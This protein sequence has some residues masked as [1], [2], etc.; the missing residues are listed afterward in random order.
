MD[1][2]RRMGIVAGL[3]FI[4]ATL[5][6]LAAA[7]LVPPRS[8]ADYLS[9]VATRS[10]Q[11]AVAALLYFVAAA[12]S[13]GIAVALYPLVRR[14][15]IG[16]AMGSVVFRTIEAVL[17]IVGVVSYLSI[18]SL[19]LSLS[20][21]RAA[22]PVADL[23]AL[24]AMGDSLLAGHDR[25]A[26]AAVLAFCLGAGMYY[27]AFYRARLVPRWLSGWGLAGSALMAVG[28]VLALFHD[29]A[30]TDYVP[31]ALPI[32]VQEIVFAVWLIVRGCNPSPLQFGTTSADPGN[33]DQAVTVP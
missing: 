26:V 31:F 9:K 7:A 23:A 1:S 25:A 27:L 24:R 19:S 32:G 6:S 4:V 13:A 22:E 21:R 20:Q 15:N 2:T 17:Y 14:V 33:A 8:G 29:T 11:M 18:L 10:D 16:V 3:L 28:A 5:A 30:V 12:C